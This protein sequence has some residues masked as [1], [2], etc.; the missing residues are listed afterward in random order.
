[1][2]SDKL[3]QLRKYRLSL[4]CSVLGLA[5]LVGLLAACG[6]NSTTTGSPGPTPPPQTQSCGTLHV[7]GKTIVPADQPYAQQRV[8]CFW[9]AYQQ[10]RPA[11]LIFS[12]SGIDAGTIHTFSLRSVNGKCTVTDA[13][14]HFIA[15][16]PPQTAGTYTCRNVA[17]QS[18]GLHISCGDLGTVTIPLAT[19]GS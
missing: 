8:N 11:T 17:L 12:A 3:Q 14:Q 7:L 4:A 6:S 5:L 13:V 2:I 15:P 18:D 9:Q 1:V 10:C 16:R 19:T